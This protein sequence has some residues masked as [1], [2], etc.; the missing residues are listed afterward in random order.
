[1]TTCGPACRKMDRAGAGEAHPLRPDYGRRADLPHAARR[2]SPRRSTGWRA[3]FDPAI[4][5][6]RKEACKTQGTARTSPKQPLDVLL[7]TN[8]I[9]VGVDVQRLGLMV[10]PASRRR[11]RSTSRP[12]A[13]S[14]GSSPA[15]SVTVFNWARPRDLSPLRDLRALPRHVLQARRGPVGHAVLARGPSSRG[16]AALLVSLVRLRGIEFNANETAMRMATARATPMS[17][18]P[19]RRSC[20]G[21]S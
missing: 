10:V 17:R 14:A 11:P 5:E 16:L 2:T 6:Q 1:M 7:A 19:S 3:V 15:W 21:P 18:T 4:E 13:G 8:M 12:P 9:S 20:G